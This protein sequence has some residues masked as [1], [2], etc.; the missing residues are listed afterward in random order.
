MQGTARRAGTSSTQGK[1]KNIPVPSFL[2]IRL[3]YVPRMA[4]LYLSRQIPSFQVS[5]FHYR[6]VTL[7]FGYYTAQNMILFG[8]VHIPT[9]DPVQYM[10]TLTQAMIAKLSTG[11]SSSSSGL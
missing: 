5:K 9:S 4:V 10:H 11:N 6:F 3:K 7:H 8:I 2:R 1:E